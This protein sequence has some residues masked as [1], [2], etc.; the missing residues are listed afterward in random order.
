MSNIANLAENGNIYEA[1]QYCSELG[2]SIHYDASRASWAFAGSHHDCDAEKKRR[3]LESVVNLG[4]GDRLGIAKLNG[5][6]L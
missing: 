6:N 5:R 1:S 2:V 4:L 3:R